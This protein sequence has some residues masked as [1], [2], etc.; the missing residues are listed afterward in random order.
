LAVHGSICR[1]LMQKH[2]YLRLWPV[3]QLLRSDLF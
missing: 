2:F 1:R 3:T